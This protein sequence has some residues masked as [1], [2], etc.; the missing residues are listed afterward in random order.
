MVDDH[1]FE[2]EPGDRVCLLGDETGQLTIQVLSRSAELDFWDGNWLDCNILIEAGGFRAT[3][4][5]N[6]R[7]DELER[8]FLD[9]KILYGSLRG[10]AIFDSMEEQ[11]YICLKGDGLGHITAEGV[12]R[13]RPGTGNELKFVLE[14]DQTHLFGTM[15]QLSE[16]LNRFP[17]RDRDSANRST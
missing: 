12:A 11:L 7:T 6:L 13:D 2:F 10:E 5:A 4:N 17:V 15:S 3:F 16:L 1:R 9:V 8:F 14:L